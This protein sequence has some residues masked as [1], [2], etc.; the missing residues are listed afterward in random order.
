MYVRVS[1]EKKS[2]PPSVPKVFASCRGRQE[3]IGKT[4]FVA[5]YFGLVSFFLVLFVLF[6]FSG[7]LFVLACVVFL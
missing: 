3:V 6:V 4:Q 1:Q 2:R 5:L 7:S